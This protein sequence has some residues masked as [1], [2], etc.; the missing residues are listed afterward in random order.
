MSYTVDEIIFQI[1]KGFNRVFFDVKGF[2]V[3]GV[4]VDGKIHEDE[5]IEVVALFDVE[6]KSK[7]EQIWPIIGKIETQTGVSIDLYPY[8]QEEL[9][10]DEDIYDEV[11][12]FGVFYDSKGLKQ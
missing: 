2:Y 11:K 8:T 4:C 3:F 10:N 9:E 1:A 6:D 7:R 12:D 5:D